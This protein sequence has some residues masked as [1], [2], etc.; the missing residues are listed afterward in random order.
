MPINFTEGEDTYSAVDEH[1]GIFQATNGWTTTTTSVEIDPTDNTVS[2]VNLTTGPEYFDWVERSKDE[3]RRADQ[4]DRLA[5]AGY[6]AGGGS[7][8]QS[9]E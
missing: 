1:K 9:T 6:T 5:R 2:K 3:T 7:T 4:L 8:V